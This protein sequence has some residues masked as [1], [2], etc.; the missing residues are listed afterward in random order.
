M[1]LEIRSC[2]PDEF[3]TFL[4]TCEAA[5]GYGVNEHLLERLQAVITTDRMFAAFDED[6]MVATLGAFP[7]TLTVPGGEASAGGVTMAGVLPSHRRRGLLSELI[8][9][10]LLDARSNEE[11]VAVLWASE[12]SIY[13]RFGYGVATRQCEMN[14]E[15]DR[16]VF[17]T[18]LRPTGR[19][20]LV[21]H[22]EAFKVLPE[23]YER[24]RRK[25]PGM[26]ARSQAWW[27]SYTLAD[28]EDE[29]HGGGPMFRAV[30]ETEGRAEAYVLYRL[31]GSWE[32][33]MP[34]GSVEV[35]EALGTSPEATR[36][37]WR[38]VFGIDLVARVRSHFLPVHHPLFHM[39]AEPRRLRLSVKDGLYL[40]L[41]D[42]PA[43][44]AARSYPIDG[45]LTIEMNDPLCRWNEGRWRVE[46]RDGR[47]NVERT[48]TPA[49]LSM[50]ATELGA[51]YLGGVSFVE[52]AQ[53]G[54][55]RELTPGAS[56]RSSLMFS[57]EVPPW[58]PEIF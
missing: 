12:S 20:R 35:K 44:L 52:L 13:G 5:F 4:E 9:T 37:I 41:V 23:I 32:D 21:D 17:D 40:R 27:Q 30:W 15:Q 55:V 42:L 58:C 7:F 39:L 25:T 24:V 36:E 43:A 10:Q 11:P 2:R 14:I 34:A 26:F 31:H 3:R 54:R 46:V 48:T 28:P 45:S 33:G 53:A 51:V 56:L 6:V 38:F 1:T 22:D 49:E 19:T 57:A 16:A 18:R 47:A 8:K 29:R 50:T